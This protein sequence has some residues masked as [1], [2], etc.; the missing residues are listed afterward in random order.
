MKQ[1]CGCCTGIEAVTPENEAN[2][3]GLSALRYRAGT[4]ATFFET[5]LADL[6][7]NYL[8]VPVDVGSTQLQRIYPLRGLTTRELSDP[9]IGLI[10]AWSVVADVLTF[11]QERIANEGFLRTAAERRSVL[12]LARLVGYRLRPGV[13]A[14]VYLAFTVSVGFDAVIPVGTRAQSLPLGSGETPQF[15]ESSEDLPAK[16]T[17]NA[18]GPRLQRPQLITLA[19][20]AKG[21]P[22]DYGTDART[23][24][25]IYLDGISTNLKTGDALLFVT[26]LGSGQQ[27]LRLALEVNVQAEDGRTEVVLQSPP[28]V[29]HGITTAMV[30]AGAL[31]PYIAEA[32]GIFADSE[33]AGEV[34]Q[35]LTQLIANLQTASH[36][37]DISE[38]ISEAIPG[39][40]EKHDLAL[41]RKFTRLEP[42][43]GRLLADLVSFAASPPGR[44]STGSGQGKPTPLQTALEPSA[45]GNLLKIAGTLGKAPSVQPANSFKLT[46]TVR[47][48]FSPQ[49]DI[50]PRLLGALHPEIA[51]TLYKAWSG[52][53]LPVQQ[54]QVYA[55]RAKAAP[56]GNNAPL[57]TVITGGTLEA[58]VEWPLSAANGDTTGDQIF[59]D[60]VYDKVVRGSWIAVNRTDNGAPSPQP[61]LFQ[62]SAADQISRADY[63]MAA[64]TTRVTLN[65]EWLDGIPDDAPATPPAGL[66][67]FRGTT[68]YAQSELLDLADEPL[69]V[70][71]EGDTIELDDVY[72]GLESGKWIIVSGERTDIPNTTGVTGTELV[73]ISSVAQGS[74]G[75][76]CAQFPPGLV[77]FSQYLYTTDANAA[78]DRLVVGMLAVTSAALQAQF[79]D[80]P[81]FP[82]QAYCDQVQLA[83][84]FY[85]NA[86]VPS[87]DELAGKFPDFDGL[88]VDSSGEPFPLG[89]IPAST[90]VSAWR[91]SSAPVHTI[92]KLA[93]ALAYTYDAHAVTLYGNVV[94]ATHGQTQGEVLG[95]GDASEAL[96]QFP[97]HQSPLTY[98]PAATASGAQSTLTVRVNEVAWQEADNLFVLGP[99]DRAY[100]TQT[101]DAGTVTVITGDGEHGLRVPSGS[102]N[103][104]AVYRSGTGSS[105]NVA[106]LQ[107][108]Q[109]AT[110]P[111]GVKS[112]INPLRA[113]GGADADTL[114][115]ARRNAPIGISALDRLVSVSDYS[116][117]ARQ[118]AGI[119]KASAR[120][121]SDGRRLLVHLTIAGKD[122]VPID[123][124][125]DLYLALQ[126]AL[127]DAGDPFQPVQI[128]LR[129]LKL[130]VIVAGVKIEAAYQWEVVAAAIRAALLDL[131][132]FDRRELGQSAFL[133]E[134]V[135]AMQSVDGVLY[136][137]MRGFGSVAESVTT[138][139]LAGLASSLDVASYIEA[140]FAHVDPTATDPASRI[141][142]AELVTLSPEIPDTLILTEIQ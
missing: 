22:L 81:L 124:N 107:I 61:M 14:S 36:A 102:S 90:G 33:L 121:L 1:P 86:Y 105:G 68:V 134:A 65:G 11:Y 120:R 118:F 104:K 97:L 139:Q 45:L 95:D 108:S 123:A 88:L 125:S 126:G 38:L 56:F 84:G 73:M 23:R 93:N 142:A 41:K 92:L 100:I 47:Q 54:V 31:T 72:V 83:P 5:M 101:D 27:A 114:E 135:S 74:R 94:K 140:E 35:S 60:A 64:K 2:R 39:I 28:D 130:L 96:Q 9:A 17:W 70:D 128:A 55:M 75:P 30:I 119:A 106:A 46:R 49:S 50:A 7:T 59:L 44:D 127:S 52:L 34:A 85:A 40:E 32:A 89:V 20:D 53:A 26:G 15:F 129:R 112:V 80:A 76:S 103:V 37:S 116:D 98:L 141:V 133:S 19:S 109:L 67:I 137:S 87:A 58:P 77:P 25:T 24:D 21:L 48:T 16:D 57:K 122:D 138:A 63:G 8:D 29:L 3:P 12:E 13:S 82:G 18:L 42:W 132:S 111:L 78:G 115:Q 51:G 62:V 136:V 71:V 110:Q 131:Y 91:I 43:L 117:F 69:D 10:D 4:Y 79:P 6:S 66:D 99:S 113:S